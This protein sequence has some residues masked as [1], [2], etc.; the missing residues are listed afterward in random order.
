MALFKILKG[1]QARLP[2][3][4][5]QGYAY[6]T[7]DKGKF[8]IFNSET[9]RRT[10]NPDIKITIGNQ[11]KTST[12]LS[13]EV[14]FDLASIGAA[15]ADHNH[16]NRYLKLSGGT[17]TGTITLLGNQYADS[18]SG[19]LNANNSNIY[20][21][22][23]IYTANLADT[24]AEGI[25]FYRTSTTVDSLWIKNGVIYFTP[26]RTLGKT[27]IDYTII[28][29]GNYTDYTVKKD[30]TGATGNWNINI[31]KNAATATK[32]QTPRSLWGNSFDGSSDISGNITLKDGDQ[33]NMQGEGDGFAFNYW[34][35]KTTPQS[36]RFY[37]GQ[38][39][40]IVRFASNGNVG[41]GTSNPTSKL[42]VNGDSLFQGETVTRI[43]RPEETKKYSLGTDDYKWSALYVSG[44][45]QIDGSIKN[46]A[47]NGGIY[48]NPYVESTDDASD[49][50]SIEVI[51]TGVAGGTQLRIQ[52]QNDVNDVVNIVTQATTGFKHNG[53]TVWD[54]TNDGP[55]S[56]ADADLL[57]GCHGSYQ[58]SPNTYVRR[59]DNGY[60]K[61]NYILYTPNKGQNP[62]IGSFV[63]T[64][65]G[66]NYLRF[67]TK[68][69]VVNQLAESPGTLINNNGHT[70]S[71][72]VTGNA[73]TYYP[74][75]I[76][77]PLE[78]EAIN[79]VSIWKNLGSQTATYTGNHDSGT[80]SMWLIYEVRKWLQ[81][82]NGGYL[83]C[84]YYSMPYAN[85]CA[86][87]S[88]AGSG[89]GK[90]VVYLRGGGTSYNISTTYKSSVSVYYQQTNL[91]DN[92]Y[93]VRV[94]PT[95]SISNSGKCSTTF[96]GYGD[97]AGNAD[98]STIPLGFAS[99][100]TNATWGNQTGTTITCW[101]QS[102]GGSVEFRRNNPSNGK[103]SIKVN[104]RF[105]GNEGSYP[106]MLIRWRN[107]YWG[108]GNPDGD[109]S[110]W[111]RTTVNGLIPFQSGGQGNGHSALGTSS[112]YFKEAFIDTVNGTNLYLRGQ[113]GNRLIWLNS[114]K[115]LDTTGHYASGSKIAVNST[116]EPGYN[117]YVNG[118]SYFTGTIRAKT[119]GS[120]WIDGQKGTDR[121]ALLV[122]DA[123][124]SDSYWPWISHHNISSKRY[125]SLGQLAN[126]IYLIGTTDT[127][128]TN[129]YDY[130]WQF[131]FSNGV[132]TVPGNIQPVSTNTQTLG[133]SSLRWAKVYIGTADTY[134]STTKGVYWNAGVPT[135]MTYELK[136]TV[137]NGTATRIAYYSGTNAVSSGSIVTDGSFLHD[138]SSLY[139][140]KNDWEFALGHNYTN[141][142]AYLSADAG[143]IRIQFQNMDVGQTY[144][145][146]RPDFIQIGKKASDGNNSAMI[147]TDN[148]SGSITANGTIKAGSNL[149]LWTD[150]QGGNIDIIDNSST[151][152][153]QFDAFDGNLRL[154]SQKCSD[155]SGFLVITLL[156]AN[157]N[158]T[159]NNIY[160][161]AQHLLINGVTWSSNW[162]WSGQGGQPAWLWG[163]NDGANMYVWNP[164]NFSVYRAKELY[165]TD[166]GTNRIYCG[167]NDSADGAGGRLN[168][169]V[170]SSWW[171][172]SFTTGCGGTNYSGTTAVGIDCRYGNISAGGSLWISQHNDTGGGLHLGDDGG[173][174]D[175]NNGYGTAAFS[176]GLIVARGKDQNNTAISLAV[177]GR[178]WA[179]S[180]SEAQFGVHCD[181]SG[182]NFYLYANGTNRGIFSAGAGSVILLHNDDIIHMYANSYHNKS[183]I[184]LKQN[185]FNLKQK[186]SINFIRQLQPVKFQFKHTDKYCFGF[187]A[188]DVL[189]VMKNFNL[190]EKDYNLVTKPEFDPN[191]PENERYYDI[192]YTE[193]IAPTIKA[194]QYLDKQ[195]EQN[196]QKEKELQQ[197]ILKLKSQIQ[198]LNAKLDTLVVSHL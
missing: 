78:K 189:K 31:N 142:D 116:E 163:S 190:K 2:N 149:Q 17:M 85:L 37:D 43:V 46:L 80:S 113:T 169:L 24:S 180:S 86:T 15:A 115:M 4:S 18:Y 193:L 26:N 197:Q 172:V 139:V 185:I 176:S 99:R 58:P 88:A 22:N 173:F 140:T 157:G 65:T 60:T 100:N 84:W 156:D 61:Q 120:S 170:I 110:D 144:T 94:S 72:T 191:H 181:S 62:S 162:N 70:Y 159:L 107:D 21:V 11:T 76:D 128:T 129:G 138:V 130:G 195:I 167:P 9:Q 146:I 108:L 82:G 5:K 161:N 131:D 184:R 106:A 48:W 154:Y 63:V 50:A 174:Y 1:Q 148:A 196:K 49:V 32:L 51:K 19:A 133:T 143:G 150:E 71:I 54:D 44:N 137:N 7:T 127:R 66:D 67:A 95:T 42:Q 89:S 59:E 134:G 74:V 168:N 13:P 164:S 192:S 40:Q 175:F 92:S 12:T 145:W 75:V 119:V 79:Y 198:L 186:Q 35:G 45:A 155:N 38:A 16:D 96:L 153:Y 136:S 114:S 182:R 125:F 23:S 123:T 41:I 171:G 188:Q 34:D 10:L 102:S 109:D 166:T 194:V 160:G 27:G 29:S 55:G 36:T 98:T 90:L 132:M 8:Y 105:Y 69:N 117:F 6:Y 20:G 121:S 68:T 47:V 178:G 103:L 25:H 91:G 187:I 177:E 57:D 53:H 81:D 152:H 28:H 135:A 126:S 141:Q 3:T 111:I 165:N 122:T 118:N 77:T 33:L 83:K 87:T 93:P 64:N 147:W 151:R 97:V 101:D 112:W 179:Y 73:N 30:G 183:D 104:G 39:N 124:D 158:T 14:A 52:Q 56:G